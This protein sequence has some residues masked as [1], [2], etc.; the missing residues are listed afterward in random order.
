MFAIDC[1]PIWR[2]TAKATKHWAFLIRHLSFSC[3][4]CKILIWW[5][6]NKLPA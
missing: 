6:H 2:N 3:S 4:F 1:Q 5:P